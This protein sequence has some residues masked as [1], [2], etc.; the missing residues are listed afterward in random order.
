MKARQLGF[1][2]RIV[3]TSTGWH[4]FGLAVLT[5]HADAAQ[6]PAPERL[7]IAMAKNTASTGTSNRL[8]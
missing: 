4:T 8:A 7:L 2:L 6:L 5:S 3:V 1:S